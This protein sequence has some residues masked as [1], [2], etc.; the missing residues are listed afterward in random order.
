MD[1]D[2]KDIKRIRTQLGLTQSELSKK[3]NVSQSLIAK[4]EAGSIDPS[5]S[6]IKRIFDTL[7]TLQ[8]VVEP[9][10]KDIMQRQVI[11]VN[12]NDA[13]KVA[14][15]KMRKNAI[16]QLPVLDNGQIIGLVTESDLLDVIT[17]AR[18]ISKVSEIMKDAPPIVAENAKA[19][20]LL[21]LL[22]FYS[23][24]IVVDKGKFKGVI[25]KADILNKM[26]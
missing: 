5:Y 26:Y 9:T 15:E 22:K 7:D 11:T 6:N 19:K 24:L 12:M 18:R 21:H 2:I 4:V 8:S 13:I 14:I 16:S 23:L 3:A 20:V 10:A 25:T 17:N 1:Y